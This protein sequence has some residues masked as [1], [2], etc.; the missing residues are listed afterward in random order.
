MLDNL[1]DNGL[2]YAGSGAL[3]TVMLSREGD[4]IYLAV[5]DNGPGVP[6]AW[7]ER[8]GERFFRVPGSAEEG[9]GL[10]L[11]IVQRIAEWHN[12]KVRYFIASKKGGLRVEIVFPAMRPSSAS[13]R[14]H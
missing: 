6:P 7:L 12:A 9:S 3:M 10:G 8:L 13:T 2:R 5:E 1:I 4:D 14:Q 11:A